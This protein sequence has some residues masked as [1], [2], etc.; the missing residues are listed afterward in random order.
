V[1]AVTLSAESPLAMNQTSG[2]ESPSSASAVER[3]YAELA[4]TYALMEEAIEGKL[5]SVPILQAEDF[6]AVDFQGRRL[7]T[8]YMAERHRQMK[9]NIRPPVW[10]HHVLGN[11][12]LEGDQAV[13]TVRQAYSRT[14][15]VNGKLRKVET[16]VTQD[17]TWIRTMAGWKRRFVENETDMEWYVD[18]KPI[19]PGR[20]FDQ[21][22]PPYESPPSSPQS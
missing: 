10:T 4:A 7:S 14:Q 17:E 2:R 20:P 18:G 3:A 5:Q 9:Q 8:E 1:Y 22:A 15:L 12:T 19:E 6:S 13:I 11:L 21:A 16:S